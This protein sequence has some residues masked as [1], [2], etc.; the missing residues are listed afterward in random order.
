MLQNILQYLSTI[1]LHLGMY[2]SMKQI[3]FLLGMFCVTTNDRLILVKLNISNRQYNIIQQRN[4][5]Y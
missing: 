1:K 3:C 4:Q 5:K 2:E